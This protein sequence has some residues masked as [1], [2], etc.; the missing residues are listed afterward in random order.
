MF[1]KRFHPFLH[2]ISYLPVLAV[3]NSP[4]HLQTVTIAMV[5][6]WISAVPIGELILSLFSS[7]TAR[8]IR[9]AFQKD[10]ARSS[11][12]F[13]TPLLS[14]LI[15]SS[16]HT[17]R[18][19]FFEQGIS[20]LYATHTCYNFKSLLVEFFVDPEQRHEKISR[21]PNF[22]YRWGFK[23]YGFAFPEGDPD[24]PLFEGN[25]SWIVIPG[26]VKHTSHLAQN[27]MIINHHLHY[28]NSLPP[29]MIES[30]IPWL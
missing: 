24:F 20:W 23:N 26:W 21:P 9:I 27:A 11:M 1:P 7:A 29:V 28:M 12:R 16:N 17:Y 15:F 10:Y 6:R 8:I 3:E 4:N 25:G 19:Q 13:R 2:T 30:L 22:Q 18:Y 5:I 14:F